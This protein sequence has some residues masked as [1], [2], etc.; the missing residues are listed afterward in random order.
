VVTRKVLHA[1]R[2]QVAEVTGRP[3]ETI[4]GF[5]RNGDGW[6]V[7]VEV[8]ELERVPNT[9]D[10]LATYA[11]TISDDGDVLGF[12]RRRRYHRAAVDEGG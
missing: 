6:V 5:H 9:M 10:L 4:S 8:L 12:E 1:A 3:V 2:Q 11:V 7:T